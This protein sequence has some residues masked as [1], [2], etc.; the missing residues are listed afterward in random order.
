MVRATGQPV[1]AVSACI[2]TYRRSTFHAALDRY[3]AAVADGAGA[4]PLIVP[5]LGDAVDMRSILERVDGLLITGS[6]SNIEPGRYGA[7][8]DTAV[9][10]SDP[11]RDGTILPLIRAC[12]DRGLPIL[13]I[14]RGF[15]EM[16]V[17]LGG[18]LHTNVHKLPGRLDHRGGP[19]E[20]ERR[21][22]PKHK[23]SL[24]EDGL[25]CQ[26]AGANEI[27]VNSLHGQAVDRLAPGLKVE[28]VAP[29]GTIEG[30]TVA[31]CQSF[32][33]GVQFH[34]EWQFRESKFNSALFAAFGEAASEHA[35]RR[36]DAGQR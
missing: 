10:P 6:P 11:A 33:A 12:L 22:R 34:P 8:A 1:I 24:A 35:R 26:L 13:G 18:T 20:V 7:S 14:C 28:A 2:R 21:Y 19:G 17:A 31:G 15:E 29:D 5:A 4:L 27:V 16:N 23:I 32:A 36:S 9:L 25:M 30:V 3:V